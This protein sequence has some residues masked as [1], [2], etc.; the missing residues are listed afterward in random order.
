M[1]GEHP[2]QDDCQP[3]PSSR[4][5]RSSRCPCAAPSEQSVSAARGYT[6][7]D[8]T[9]YDSPG[10]AQ[11][12]M[13][14]LVPESATDQE[15]TELLNQLLQDAS[16]RTGFQVPRTPYR[17]CHFPSREHA[18]SG[19]GQWE[20]MVLKTPLDPEPSVQFRLG[21]GAIDEPANRFGLTTQERMVAYRQ[22]V[23]AEDRGR[24]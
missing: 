15:L 14:I 2:C 4:S 12:T 19:M 8:E 17:C 16:Q 7:L 9:L 10:K 3:R 11:V 1:Q 20:A 22:L 13:D 23:G 18:D 21:R 6:L 5:S 24:T